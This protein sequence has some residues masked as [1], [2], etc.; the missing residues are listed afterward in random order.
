[1]RDGHCW[2]GDQL[3]ALST[4]SWRTRDRAYR[5]LQVPSGQLRREEVDSVT[6]SAVSL[7]A[8]NGQLELLRVRQLGYFT[9]VRIEVLDVPAK[10][11][12]R[13]C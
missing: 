3:E 2:G 13:K 9:L 1:M 12:P 5:L 6:V 4:A 7:V 8:L 10:G 11:R